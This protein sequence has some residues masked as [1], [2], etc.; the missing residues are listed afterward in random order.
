MGQHELPRA[1]EIEADLRRT[2]SMHSY[3]QAFDA[4]TEDRPD[5]TARYEQ[6]AAIGGTDAEL[7]EY[8]TWL[9]RHYSF[10]NQP[11]TVEALA[12]S[13]LFEGFEKEIDA[14]LAVIEGLYLRG[15]SE[16]AQEMLVT[17]AARVN[18]SGFIGTRR[19]TKKIDALWEVVF[20]AS[21]T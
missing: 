9:I 11:D 10:K 6:Q 15:D 19:I 13:K 1:Q 7:T 20:P 3:G 17:I 8:L 14:N 21:A 16:L 4:H 5:D 18:D 12:S 2:S